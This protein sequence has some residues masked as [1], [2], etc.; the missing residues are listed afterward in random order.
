MEQW[1]AKQLARLQKQPCL[2][3][4]VPASA[5]PIPSTEPVGARHC[6]RTRRGPRPDRVRRPL[7]RRD[8]RGVDRDMGGR[9][10][11]RGAPRR[12][13]AGKMFP[14]SGNIFPDGCPG[15]QPRGADDTSTMPWVAEKRGSEGGGGRGNLRA[16]FLL[17]NKRP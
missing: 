4:E 14:K 5:E 16:F 15:A 10:L 7:T 9:F 17:R 1:T 8:H 12:L 2:A 11:R 3:P 13:T 6:P